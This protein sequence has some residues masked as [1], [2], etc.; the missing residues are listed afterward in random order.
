[1]RARTI[2]SGE[3]NDD[4]HL[5]QER[6]QE[7]GG[8]GREGGG[9][10]TAAV[11]K[12]QKKTKRKDASGRGMMDDW[13]VALSRLGSVVRKQWDERKP[14]GCVFVVNRSVSVTSIGDLRAAASEWH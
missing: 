11:E 14:S 7:K 1:M 10:E 9:K 3:A 2:M 5:A 12:K 8:W 6:R 4:S 13:P